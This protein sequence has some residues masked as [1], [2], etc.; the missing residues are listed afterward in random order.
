MLEAVELKE[1]F[2]VALSLMHKQ[3]AVR[4]GVVGVWLLLVCDSSCRL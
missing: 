1:R 4:V 2:S 3:I